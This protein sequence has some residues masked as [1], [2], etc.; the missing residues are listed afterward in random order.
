MNE[1]PMKTLDA[2]CFLDA[3]TRAIEFQQKQ[4]MNGIEVAIALTEVRDAVKYAINPKSQSDKT[5]RRSAMH[6]KTK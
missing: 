4:P 6:H 3:L 2:Q 5:A 1:T